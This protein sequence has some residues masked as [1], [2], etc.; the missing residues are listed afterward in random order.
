MACRA[1]ARSKLPMFVSFQVLQVRCF[2]YFFGHW[3]YFHLNF[4]RGDCETDALRLWHILAYSLFCP[5]GIYYKKFSVNP[6]P[7]CVFKL[8]SET[9]NRSREL[10]VSC[11][12]PS[13]ILG[14]HRW[15]QAH[16]RDRS[17]SYWICSREVDFSSVIV[18]DCLHLLQQPLAFTS[19]TTFR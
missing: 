14:S 15:W 1:Y 5:L 12:W 3:T 8:S 10:S 7:P 2:W 9:L 11:G 17:L 4:A 19:L 16:L 6:Q 13:K 18:S